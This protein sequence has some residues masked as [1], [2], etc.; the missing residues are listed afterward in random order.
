MTNKQISKMPTTHQERVGDYAQCFLHGED[1]H[2]DSWIEEA[3]QAVH[4]E[5]GFLSLDEGRRVGCRRP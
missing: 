1:K 3:T 4:A 2:E 5:G